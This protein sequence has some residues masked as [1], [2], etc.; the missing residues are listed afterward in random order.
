MSA[1]SSTTAKNATRSE[2]AEQA[3]ISPRSLANQVMQIA[4]L[5]KQNTRLLI[6]H[7]EDIMR[8]DASRMGI[9]STTG[10]P[11]S[12]TSEEGG[13]DGVIGE[14]VQELQMKL[15]ELEERSIRRTANSHAREPS[16][17]IDWMPSPDPDVPEPAPVTLVEF[18]GISAESL[19]DS[20]KFYGLAHY[21]DGM[22]LPDEVEFA[23]LF[24]E[25]ARFLGVR[26]R[27]TVGKSELK[28]SK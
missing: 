6:Q 4:A 18:E 8:I 11:V 20:M 19:L 25:C 7:G 9:S 23:D 17:T 2:S 26:S 12:Q 21:E 24:N 5:V 28:A 3:D 27:K 22:A 14:L 16:D 10:E 15:D 1:G 13:Q